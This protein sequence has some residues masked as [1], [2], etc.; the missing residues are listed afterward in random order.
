MP[1]LNLDY[2]PNKTLTVREAS[3]VTGVK[4]A[5]INRLIDDNVLP[6]GT[7]MRRGNKRLLPIYSI[8]MVKFGAEDGAKL[9]KGLRLS[10]MKELM[11]YFRG[12]DT[13]R[14]ALMNLENL[15]YTEGA[16]KIDLSSTVTQVAEKLE[17]LAQSEAAITVDPDIRSG[18]PVIKGTRIDA[19]DVAAIARQHG[20]KAV[21]EIY[22]QLD[23]EK[24]NAAVV[25][26]EAHPR[27]GRPKNGLPSNAQIK[28]IRNV[29]FA[30]LK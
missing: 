8:A 28:K 18:N 19:H 22:P 20:E 9:G 6:R 1:E 2:K 4:V 25:Y 24:I 5:T 7:F 27:T 26:A 10:V 15:N 11:S 30:D 23:T 16:I 12:P 13:L 17:S 14:K 21:L 3:V 29:S